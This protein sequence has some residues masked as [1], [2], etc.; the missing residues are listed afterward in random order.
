MSEKLCRDTP[1]TPFCLATEAAPADVQHP[2]RESPPADE[3]HRV[4]V[5]REIADTPILDKEN[6][7]IMCELESKVSNV[8]VQA[9]NRLISPR[10][11]LKK[12]P[13]TPED[14]EFVR[15]TRLELEH[16]ICGTS[17]KFVV[18]AGPC[19]IHD[20]SG[21]V[22]YATRLSALCTRFSKNLLIIMRVYFEKPRTTV[23][24][25]GYIYDPHLDG[26]CQISEGLESARRLLKDITKL[27]VPIACE[28]LDTITPQYLSDFVSWGAIGART[29]ES[30]I[31]RQLASGLSMPVGFKNA[32]SGSIRVAVD[33]ML[34]AR[35]PHVFCGTDE[36][37]RCSVVH[38]LGNS[39]THVVLRG[40]IDKT[41]YDSASIEEAE[42]MMRAEGLPVAVLV[43]CSHDNSRKNYK[44]QRAVLSDVLATFKAVRNSRVIGVMIE[45][46]LVEGKQPIG[47][48]MNFGQSVTDSCVGWIETVHLV[49]MISQT[50]TDKFG[51]E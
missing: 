32:T 50:V 1:H 8:R 47:P 22:E 49:K 5:A 48:H 3:Q 10:E 45:S 16:I 24:W 4:S 2:H 46:N 37:G 40:A 34:S 43:D 23:G 35:H 21:A 19:S 25:K 12:I 28:F 41:N 30:Q 33:A 18:I 29:V 51:A 26:T 36:D 42:K 13:M 38:T 44:N 17:D 15:A 11:L 6:Q 9:I 14:A 31:H 27:R 39:H 20:V 7:P